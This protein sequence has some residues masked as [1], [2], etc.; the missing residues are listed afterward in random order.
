MWLWINHWDLTGRASWPSARHVL[1]PGCDLLA[2]MVLNAAREGCILF[3]DST[4]EQIS[5]E[6]TISTSAAL[7]GNDPD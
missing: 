4:V 3:L 7:Y 6:I 1:A 5:R 2:A